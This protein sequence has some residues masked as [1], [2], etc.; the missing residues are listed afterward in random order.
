MKLIGPSGVLGTVDECAYEA[1]QRRLVTARGNLISESPT[2]IT[3]FVSEGRWVADCPCCGSGI[4]L[5]R[6]WRAGRC[7]L[8]GAVYATVLWPVD[9]DAIED[10]LVVRLRRSTQNWAP[11]ETCEMLI[12][13][14]LSHGSAVRRE[15]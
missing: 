11:S 2:A 10:A 15:P 7:Y 6:D 4:S 12:N 13:E 5:H 1:R 14:N 3:A 8:C 9:F